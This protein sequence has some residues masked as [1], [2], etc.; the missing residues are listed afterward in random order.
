[1]EWGGG[2]VGLVCTCYAIITAAGRVSN[3]KYAEG[4]SNASLYTIRL[5]ITI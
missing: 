5:M 4:K 2:G 1:M 3:L